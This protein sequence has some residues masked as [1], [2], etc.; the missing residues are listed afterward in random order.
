M[1]DT[2]KIIDIYGTP[3]SFTI[4]GG[5]LYKTN[6][7]GLITTLTLIS[8]VISFLYFGQ[9]FYLRRKPKL[10]DDGTTRFEYSNF[11]ISN[12][13]FFIAVNY[14]LLN[15]APFNATGHLNLSLTY[16]KAKGSKVD[17]TTL[18]GMS[19]N[20]YNTTNLQLTYNLTKLAGITCFNLTNLDLGG[21]FGNTWV[22]YLSLT[23][24]NCINSSNVK[25]CLER[26]NS[27]TFMNQNPVT[28]NL[29]TNNIYTNF[30]DVDYPLKL[31]L[32]NINSRLDTGMGNKIRIFYKDGTSSLDKALLTSLPI[33]NTLLGYDTAIFSTSLI[34]KENYEKPDFSFI[35]YE[36]FYGLNSRR[37]EVTYI[38]LQEVFANIGGILNLINIFFGTIARFLNE[39]NKTL[40]IINQI[41]D[42]NAF[43]NEDQITNIIEIK[44]KK[45][46]E[47]KQIILEK[48]KTIRTPVINNIEFSNLGCDNTN[49]ILQDKSLLEG[50]S[51]KLE[52]QNSNLKDKSDMEEGK[53]IK[54]DIDVGNS[55][56]KSNEFFNKIND[57]QNNILA[58]K[59]GK[60]L[61]K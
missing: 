49:K 55:P 1:S 30:S 13:N 2:F 5:P 15:G 31:G 47:K 45:K 28:V 53:T 3:F 26:N 42:F 60:Y 7:G 20:N 34:N 58:V 44:E 25:N 29:Y 19:C 39:H 21:Y 59:E 37:I 50:K 36:F 8:F 27:V 54:L 38:K 51:L 24:S 41:F 4:F 16:T 43:K 11:G 33:N 61:I 22:N 18:L 10:L 12:D 52:V 6:C 23:V 46:L 40:S 14:Q 9:D 32:Q 56:D 48:K 57:E 35:K 17:E